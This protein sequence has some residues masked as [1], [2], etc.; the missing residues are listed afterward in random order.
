MLELIAP[1]YRAGNLLLTPY[2]GGGALLPQGHGFTTARPLPQWADSAGG[3]P[4]PTIGGL[5][6][7]ARRGT[8][9]RSP[10]ST[11]QVT[12]TGRASLGPETC[13]AAPPEA[14]PAHSRPAGM[15]ICGFQSNK[16][17]GGWR[18]RHSHRRRMAAERL[19]PSPAACP[20]RRDAST[21]EGRE[22]KRQALPVAA[23]W[24]FSAGGSVR[25]GLQQLGE[26][27]AAESGAQHVA[28]RPPRSRP[29]DLSSSAVEHG[30]FAG[31][32]AWRRN[33]H[34]CT[35]EEQR[36]PGDPLKL[37]VALDVPGR[38]RKRASADQI[39]RRQVC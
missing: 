6:A 23:A 22:G 8:R 3:S 25:L 18:Y 34:A 1:D 19:H 26:P 4:A 13:Y 39:V 21:T 36:N 14:R 11:R 10:T 7:E 20:G 30:Y 29:T 27:S 32:V 38:R 17:A 24:Q 15:G 33:L 9:Y 2:I 28:P 31:V 37:L 5:A 16:T 12:A 35:I